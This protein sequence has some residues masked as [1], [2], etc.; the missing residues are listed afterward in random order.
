M[1]LTL[2]VAPPTGVLTQLEQL[3]IPLGVVRDALDGLLNATREPDSTL[4]LGDALDA[5]ERGVN[6]WLDTTKAV[7]ETLR[8]H[9]QD[10]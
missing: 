8:S 9:G 1:W 5:I 10:L 4:R 3:E 2:R 6:T 7:E